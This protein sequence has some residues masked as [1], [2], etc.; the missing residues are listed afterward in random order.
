V[1]ID[2][3][4]RTVRAIDPLFFDPRGHLHGAVPYGSPLLYELAVPG[5]ASSIVE[6]RFTE[7]PV[8]EWHQWSSE[9][10]RRQGVVGAAG[11]SVVRA[12]RE[13]DYGWYLMGSKRRENYD[14]WWRC[15]VRFS[16]ELDEMF[17]VTHSKQGVT[18]TP[19]LRA[20]LAPDLETIARTLNTRVRAAFE[21][22]KAKAQSPAAHTASTVDQFLPPPRA[23]R[24]RVPADGYKYR[25]DSA[26][27]PT[28]EFYRVRIVGDT[29][30]VTLNRDHPFFTHLYEPIC[31]ERSK[32]ERYHVECILLSAVRAELGA[33]DTERECV[34]RLRRAWADAL[35]TFLDV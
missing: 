5:G 11:V 3:N 24:R 17:G 13:I 9:E 26:S 34:S 21:Q 16:P 28:P 20:I 6:V 32:H 12:G 25:I 35:A 8:A 18:P 27:L 23:H 2:V 22:V 33:G 29:A 30:V 14:D 10:K 1:R 15:E 7:L 4:G 31:R 19:G